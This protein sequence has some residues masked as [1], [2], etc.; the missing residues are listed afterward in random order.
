MRH[1]PIACPRCLHE[2]SVRIRQLDK[3]FECEACGTPFYVDSG[4]ACVRGKRPA[5]L[6]SAE[7]FGTIPRRS[8]PD[9]L[10]A[11]GRIPRSAFVGLLAAALIGGAWL[12]ARAMMGR[13]TATVPESLTDRADYV[14][15]RLH[16]GDEAAIAALV[17]PGTEAEARR[18]YT[19]R[20]NP[21]WSIAATSTLEVGTTVLFRRES[22]RTAATVSSL[23]LIGPGGAS[24][25]EAPRSEIVLFWRL[26]DDNLWR[27]D[28]RNTLREATRAR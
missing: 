15:G 13:V 16:A 4:G 14:I 8:G 28:G 27:I 20:R 3:Q 25:A 17:V 21:S 23:R 24:S 9:P 19:L 5:R 6:P 22:A 1:L 18:W 10:E 11:L 12:V 7:V 2:H 26:G